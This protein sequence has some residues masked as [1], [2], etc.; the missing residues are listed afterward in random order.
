MDSARFHHP[1][2]GCAH[3]ALGEMHPE[4]IGNSAFQMV[5]SGKGKEIL[6]ENKGQH[7]WN[8]LGRMHEGISNEDKPIH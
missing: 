4:Q 6:P 1:P 5:E 7:R 8:F 2:F 3:P